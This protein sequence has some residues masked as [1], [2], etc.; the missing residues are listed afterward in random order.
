MAAVAA[1]A[2]VAAVVAAMFVVAPASG[3]AAP[4]AAQSNPYNRGPDP[5]VAGIEASR[6]PFATA[7]MGVAPGNGFNGGVIYYP[8]ETTLGTWGHWRSC[9]AT[10]HCAPRRRPGW[11]RGSPRSDSW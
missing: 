11:A 1:L 9:R 2:A 6:G 4:R 7:Q 8:T 5:T 10:R 3:A